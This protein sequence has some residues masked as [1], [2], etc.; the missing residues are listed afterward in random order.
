[1]DA[2]DKHVSLWGWGAIAGSLFALLFALFSYVYLFKGAPEIVLSGL[3]VIGVIALLVALAFTAVV[4]K[5][6]GLANPNGVLGLPE[7]SM[8]A[9]I[10]LSL[11]LIFI[12]S[13]IFL[14]W[15]VNHNASG[16]I[17][18]STD[19][20]QEE[21]NGFPK[22][23]IV[24]INRY[25]TNDNKTYFT[26]KRLVNRSSDTSEDIAKQIIT[27]VSTLV[28]A[29]AGFYFGTRAVAVAKGGAP[30]ISEPVIHDIDPKTGNQDG[31]IKFRISGK[32]FDLVRDV[33]L[34]QNS[35]EMLCKEVA[36]SSTL[37]TCTLKIDK[38]APV[39]KW[40]LVVITSDEVKN[41]LED[42][43]E[44]IAVQPEI[45]PSGEIKPEEQKVDQS[46][47][48]EPKNPPGNPG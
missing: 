1:M 44:V 3:L 8:R 5:S 47:S 38:N 4:F 33:K 37:V 23:Q 11:I 9:V 18:T 40:A 16:E 26:V 42:A 41:R 15:Q 12:M 14:Y 28:V 36:T 2:G 32:N 7:G 45:P 21:L 27:T 43:F 35:L 6:L 25:V 46:K 10:A 29:V 39:G 20:T 48:D 30:G 24:S 17:F 31:E 34:V 22:E 19:I 13:S